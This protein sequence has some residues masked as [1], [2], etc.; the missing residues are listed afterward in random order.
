[1]MLEKR[2]KAGQVQLDLIGEFKYPDVR[3]GLKSEIQTI[4]VK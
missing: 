2:N 1:M 4:F 3:K